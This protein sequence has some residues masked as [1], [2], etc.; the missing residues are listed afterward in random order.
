MAAKTSDSD[1]TIVRV[2]RND[3]PRSP[4]DGSEGQSGAAEARRYGFG[5]R[6][7]LIISDPLSA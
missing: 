1:A 2:R 3:M 4:L 5:T 7:V 6:I